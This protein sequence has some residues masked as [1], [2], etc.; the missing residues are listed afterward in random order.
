[1]ADS[2]T[3]IPDQ[4]QAASYLPFMLAGN[5]G[6]GGNGGGWGAGILGFIIGALVGNRGLGGLFGGNNGNGMDAGYVAN[7]LNN[8]TGRELI[9]Q[10][11]NGNHE[12]IMNLSTILHA[13]LSTVQSDIN[14]VS[15]AIQSLGS[16]V[17]LSS[18]QIINSIQQGNAGLA[19]QLCQCCCE[20]RQL[21]IEQGY[22]NQIRTL[23]QTTAL[24]GQADRNTAAITAAIANQ[25]TMINEKF[26]DLEKREMQ[27]KITTLTA[28][29]TLLRSQI[30]NAAQTAQ[31]AG[32]IAPLAHEV[33]DIKC[34]L[35]NTVPV[36]YP[37]IT[38]VNN[39]P[40]MGGFYGGFPGY[41]YGFGFNNGLVF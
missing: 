8:D 19:S 17:G 29:N 40:N 5:H 22:Q 7:A 2:V 34:K 6:L 16:Q 23:E 33:N 32:L 1:M 12:A 15:L 18:Q 4:N 21:T 27:D 13:D 26:C 38:A 11:V 31:I 25:T 3:Y 10:A 30:D 36:T 39:T 41:G 14:T 9:I 24:S 20:M 35:P 28:N 37:N